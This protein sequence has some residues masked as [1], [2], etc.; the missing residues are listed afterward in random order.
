MVNPI[1]QQLHAVAG[2]ASGQTTERA[3]A[4]MAGGFAQELQR[5]LAKVSQAQEASYAKAQSFELGEPGVALS[6]VMIDMQK[7]GIAFQ[8][9]L[10]VRNRLVSA[11]QEVASMPV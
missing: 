9:A 7:A 5:S 8:T 10:Q 3:T 4:T 11:Y 6:D 1:L 2:L